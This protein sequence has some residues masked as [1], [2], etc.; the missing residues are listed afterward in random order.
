MKN[1]EDMTREN[2][3]KED[4]WKLYKQNVISVL[5]LKISIDDNLYDSERDNTL[6]EIGETL[7]FNYGEDNYPDTPQE[8]KW[9]EDVLEEPWRE[10]NLLEN[11]TQFQKYFQ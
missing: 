6:D 1:Y 5:E 8:M 9:I 2:I 4:V 10:G 11:R 3:T 7:N